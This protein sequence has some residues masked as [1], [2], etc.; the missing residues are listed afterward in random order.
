VRVAQ[1]DWA[2]A[3]RA[4]IEVLAGAPA[5]AEATRSLAYALLRQDRAREAIEVL[6]QYLEGREDPTAAALL[7][8]IRHH[9]AAEAGLGEQTLSHFRVRYDGDAHEDVG[10]E[11]LRVLERHYVTLTQTFGHQ[12]AESIPVIL[13]SRQS[14][15]DATGAPAWSGGSFDSFD[16]RVRIPIGGLTTSLD[17]ELDE[18]ILHELTHVFITDLSAGLAPREIQEGVAQLVAG[19]HGAA[20]LEEAELRA[21][22]NDRLSGVSDFYLRSLAFVEDLVAQRGQGGINDLLAAMRRS[23]SVDAAFREVYGKD[24]RALQTDAVNRLRQRYRD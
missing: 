9:N 1:A 6:S 19:H 4:A 18:T 11:V 24:M 20:R 17:P 3:E 15:Y 2:G 8:R 10:R 23:R 14:Y 5:D 7:A 12:P 22:A 13:F 16:G 21:L